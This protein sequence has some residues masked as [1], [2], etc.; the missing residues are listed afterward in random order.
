[1]IKKYCYIVAFGFLGY[2][3]SLLVHAGIEIPTLAL[4]TGEVGEYGNNWVWQN[5]EMLHR[6]VGIIITL[7]GVGGG[8]YLGQRFWQILYVEKRYGTPR[9]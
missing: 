6:G 4:I 5:W 8:L 7:L 1:M 9:W 3:V 2:L